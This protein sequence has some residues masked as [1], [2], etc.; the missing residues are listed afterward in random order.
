MSASEHSHDGNSEDSQVTQTGHLL[1]IETELGNDVLLLRALDGVETVSRGFLYNI[2]M[3]TL[4]YDAEVRA[5]LGKPVTLWLRNDVETVRRPLHGCIRHLTQLAVDVRGYRRWQAEVVP[6]MWFLTRSVDCRIFQDLTT[7]DIIRTVFD[8]QGLIN[9]ELR[10][11]DQ[12]P[13][14]IFCVQY[15]ESAFSFVSRLMEHAGIFYW[16]EHHRDRHVL[17]VADNN[18]AAKLTEPQEALLSL[19]PDLGY[20][21]DLAHDFTF[22]TGNWALSDFDFEVPTKDLRTHEPTVLDVPS[23]K[24]FETFDYPG[25]YTA[26][27]EGKKLTRLRI[28]EEE[29]R[30]H[31]LSGSG[32]CVGFDAGKQ[33]T[34][35]SEGPVD[36]DNPCNYLLTEV[37]HVA[38]DSSHF[39]TEVE[40]A[41]YGNRFV[42]IP[43]ATPFRPERLTSKP[44]VQGPQTATV[45]G[46][47]GENIHTDQYGRVRALFHWDRRGK[48]DE[49]ASCWIRVSQF[50]AGSHW[51][52]LAIPHVGQEVVV[53]FMEGD[54]DRPIVTGHVHNG[55]NM[56]PLNLPRDQDK[57]IIRD[58]GD[59]KIIMQGKASAQHLSMVSPHTVN[60]IAARPP[61]KPLS[62]DITFSQGGTIEGADPYIDSNAF[63]ELNQLLEGFSSPQPRDPDS[64]NRFKIPSD[65]SDTVSSV[66]VNTI[67]EG[68]INSLSGGNT[69]S[70]VGGNM[71]TWVGGDM[72]QEVV[73]KTD[74]LSHGDTT[75]TYHSQVTDNFDTLHE[76]NTTM[77]NEFCGVHSEFTG[78]HTEVTAA[79]IEN[80]IGIH[81]EF[82]AGIH[83]DSG[84]LYTSNYSLNLSNTL[85]LLKEN[86][87]AIENA[88][89]KILNTDL[90]LD[91]ATLKL[92]LG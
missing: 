41:T 75:N 3:L 56:P 50:S 49:H 53:A 79:H 85:T 47:A 35:A 10:L 82:T 11:Q 15:R 91:Q 88:V 65:F 46:P 74:T 16:F 84:D 83:I 20:I 14:H 33:F 9:Y 71:N 27:A 26:S 1:A 60:L 66:D 8:E 39:S 30:H 45:V 72:N 2:E 70:W 55:N 6:F 86:A 31:R 76:E 87:T 51:G 17:V 52:S 44:V 89:I 90:H 92:I 22:R 5:L 18:R 34:L 13:K 59:N 78:I 29:A 61:A 36:R 38:R 67:A 43:I 4:A 37:R 21:Q 64:P 25:N 57:T 73:G 12:Y 62:S 80:T 77:H 24:R 23:M 54:P 68:K 40:P 32:S 48:R 19:R 7:P 63:T 81:S 28:E 42:A 69:N 58:Q